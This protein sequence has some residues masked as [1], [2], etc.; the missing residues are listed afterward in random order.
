MTWLITLLQALNEG[1]LLAIKTTRISTYE[2]HQQPLPKLPLMWLPAAWRSVE[3]SEHFKANASRL[4][5]KHIRNHNNII[6]ADSMFTSKESPKMFL[7]PQLHKCFV[8]PM[9]LTARAH[10]LQPQRS[11]LNLPW[12][13][14]TATTWNSALLVKRLVLGGDLRKRFVVR[15]F[16]SDFTS[17]TVLRY[18]QLASS[19]EMKQQ[20]HRATKENITSAVL[21]KSDQ[22]K[23]VSTVP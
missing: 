7:S 11:T 12:Q 22:W 6:N 10:L 3:K 20:Y 14:L 2:A 5:L 19:R 21:T 16:S 4:T 9:L 18:L 1:M 15:K 17:R 8:R 13:L 23:W